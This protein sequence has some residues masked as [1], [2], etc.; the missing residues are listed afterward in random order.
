MKN[1]INNYLSSLLSKTLIQICII[2]FSTIGVNT[3]C[4]SQKVY[5]DIWSVDINTASIEKLLLQPE[6]IL[7]NPD[8]FWKTDSAFILADGWHKG[9][10][11]P[12]DHKNYYN[13]WIDF[14]K[15]QSNLSKAEREQNFAF[16]QL[17]KLKSKVEYF[18]SMS[19]P[20]L[21]SFM[22]KNNLTFKT[23]V[24]IT[25]KTLAFGFMH[26]G[27]V[28]IDILSPF[29]KNDIEKIYNTITHE[30]FH[31]GYGY[32]RY[33]RKEI[34]LDNFFIYN[35]MLDALQNEGI[36]TYL[37]FLATDF[38]P[39]ENHMDYVQ[40]KDFARIQYHLDEINMLFAEAEVLPL[41]SLKK[42]SWKVGIDNRTYYVIG[43]Y[44]AATIDSLL[45][46]EALVNT[47]SEGPL[48]FLETYNNLVSSD[49]KII[50][51]QRPKD[52]SC[53]QLLKISVMTDNQNKFDSLVS[54]LLR[55]NKMLPADS[56]NKFE[57]LGYQI[58]FQGKP[59]WAIQIF[60]LDTKLFPKS[61]NAFDCLGEAY[62]KSGDL[63]N[64]KRCYKIA[65]SIDP[66][67]FN[68]QRML[69]EIE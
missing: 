42:K 53:I 61:A 29:Y 30:C 12:K 44:M 28:I 5:A 22:P 47:I 24:Y 18:D 69:S 14:L 56:Q 10:G 50:S 65:L 9:A 39:V 52:L 35:T 8:V 43:A 59:N 23:T 55:R 67:F 51:F 66:D 25:T 62:L 1:L 11:I 45:G 38:F 46:R 16:Q 40:L 26:N 49:K 68:A 58:L 63:L 19:I 31:I 7:K 15:N 37:G 33:H 60:Q 48:N 57:R 17:K 64:A 13:K 34:E 20:L 32:N 36:A 2:I 41:D 3:V 54:G 6:E 21:N 27:Q 4:F